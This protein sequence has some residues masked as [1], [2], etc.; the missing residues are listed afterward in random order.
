[1]PCQRPAVGLK[2]RLGRHPSE[3]EIAAEIG[4]SLESLQRLLGDLRGLD[5]GSLQSETNDPGGEEE[6]Q[7]PAGSEKE[8]PYH[9]AVR[10]EMM[11]LLEKAIGELADREREVLA[12]YHF[13]ELTMKQVGALLGIGESRV[14]QIHSA[15]LVRLRAR[16]RELT[17][18]VPARSK[19]GP[20]PVAMRPRS[21]AV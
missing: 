8:D 1:M 3:P 6:I 4:V 11:G 10:S 7:V 2:A 20:V 9:Q 21:V 12:L 18:A 13:E 15:A 16:L 19:P 17:G 5:I 14:S